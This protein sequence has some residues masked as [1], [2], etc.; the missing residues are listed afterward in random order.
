M[1]SVG[2]LVLDRRIPPRIEMNDGVGASEVETHAAGLETDQEH[3]DRIRPLKA[4][5]D[6]GPIHRRTVEITELDRFGGE[7]L[8]EHR[9]HAHE[10]AENPY[11][12]PAADYFLDPIAEHIQLA[13]R[14]CGV[15]ALKF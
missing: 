14:G 12:M 2:G 10:L 11:P 3:G 5:H 7:P 9:Q 15:D 13:R 6:R 8:L 4:V 1:R